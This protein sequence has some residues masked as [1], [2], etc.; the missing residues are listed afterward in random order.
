MVGTGVV[1]IRIRMPLCANDLFPCSK[2]KRINERR[3]TSTQ[4]NPGGSEKHLESGRN[5]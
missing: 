1:V 4:E 5:V 2:N 3:L